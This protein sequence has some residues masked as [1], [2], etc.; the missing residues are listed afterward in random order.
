[1]NRYQLYPTSIWEAARP[2]GIVYDH[3]FYTKHSGE[4]RK[5]QGTVTVM[6]YIVVNGARKLV[7]CARRVRWDGYG[8][9]FVGTHNLRKRRYDIPLKSIVLEQ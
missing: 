1:M 9:C 4:V 5:V 6:R 7:P 8:Y 3:F 2:A